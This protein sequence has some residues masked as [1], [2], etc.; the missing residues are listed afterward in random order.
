MFLILIQFNSI[1]DWL[2][3]RRHCKKDYQA[4]LDNIRTKIRLAIRDMPQIEE[5]TELLKSNGKL[6]RF[7]GKITL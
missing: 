1:L 7:F 5:V 4:S 2:I 3:S 6:S